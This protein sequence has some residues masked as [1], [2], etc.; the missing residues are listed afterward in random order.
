MFADNVATTDVATTAWRP[1]LSSG[2][3]LAATCLNACALPGFRT[4]GALARVRAQIGLPP[5]RRPSSVLSN[6]SDSILRTYHNRRNCQILR[7]KLNGREPTYT[8]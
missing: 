5:G 2:E 6:D 4:V 8:L 3:T 7:R 1:L